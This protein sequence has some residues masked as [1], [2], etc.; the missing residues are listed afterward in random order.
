LIADANGIL[1]LLKLLSQENTDF[2][3]EMANLHNDTIV[4]C[5]RLLYLVCKDHN[6]RIVNSLV[7]FKSQVILK[8]L[9]KIPKFEII[10]LKLL[11]RMVRYL[12]KN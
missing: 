7:H 12:P 1:V 6:G 9:I 4:E 3:E 10:S 2:V 5:L 8:K 11:K